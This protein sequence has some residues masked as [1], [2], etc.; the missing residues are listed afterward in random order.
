VS[1]IGVRPWHDDRELV[2]TDP[3]GTVGASQVHRDLRGGV[4]KDPVARGVTA[5]VIDLL[6]VVE[7]DDGQRE[8]HG[9]ARGHRPLSLDLLL[10]PSMVAKPGQR[11]TERL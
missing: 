4:A 5:D 11:V 8:R 10:E 6:E 3:K 9:V 2:A 7:V 1:A